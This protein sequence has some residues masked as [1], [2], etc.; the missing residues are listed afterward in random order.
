MEQPRY[1]QLQHFLKVQIQQGV[2]GIGDF[3][4]SEHDL[5]HKFQ[6]TRT[7]VRKAL[8]ELQKE[9]FI[10]RQHG[11]GSLV[12]ERR[13][14]LGLLTIKGFSAAVG[15]GA[16][17]IFLKQPDLAPWDLGFPFI[18]G[19]DELAK[20]C[21]YFERLRKVGEEPAMIDRNWF[22][23]VETP[24]FEQTEFIDGSFFKTLSKLYGIEI[25]GSEHEIR[26]ITADEQIAWLLNIKPSQPILNVAIR[27]STSKRNFFVY[28]ELFCNT[29]KYPISNSYH[30]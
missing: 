10:E 16:S 25:T 26:A 3:L 19:K 23:A 29:V 30:L 5:C 12:R 9:G 14:S 4:P 15:E 20:P 1:R 18:P 13:K 7:T 2:Y 22:S 24:G 8:E 28:S 6:V 27:F 17:T 21:V 11:R